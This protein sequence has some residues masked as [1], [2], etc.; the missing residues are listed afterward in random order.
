[1]RQITTTVRDDFPRYMQEFSTTFA[2]YAPTTPVYFSVSLFGYAGGLRSGDED[3]GLYF[4]VDELARINGNLKIVIQ[5]ELFHQ[6]HYQISPDVVNNVTAWVLMWEEGLATYVSYRVNPG[7]MADQALVT[8][9]RLSELAKP[10]LP[11]LARRILNYAD[12]TDSESRNVLGV[13][14]LRMQH[15]CQPLYRLLARHM[16]WTNLA[17]LPCRTDTRRT[18]PR[19]GHSCINWRAAS[20]LEHSSLRAGRN[21]RVRSETHP[22]GPSEEPIGGPVH[23]TRR[24]EA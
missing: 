5:H 18:R 7:S 1:M 20:Y 13:H 10:H 19:A 3:T 9:N 14:E 23:R 11:A 12:S 16:P 15:R 6:Y 22:D 21:P 17:G 8:P 24:S 4:G 2:D